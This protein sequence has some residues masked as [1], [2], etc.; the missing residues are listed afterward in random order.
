VAQCTVNFTN[1]KKRPTRVDNEAKAC[2]DDVAL[3]MGRSS[4]A[5]LSLVANEDADEQKA[6]AKHAKMKHPKPSAA[7][8]RAVNTK[9]YLVT[10]KGLDPSRIMVYTGTDDAQTVTTTL[11]PA[12]AANPAAGDTAVDESAVKAVPRTPPAKPMKKKKSM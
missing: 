7:A 1:D 9:D 12:G 6:D 5:K 8:Q 3:A 10:E 4:D 11:V 2:L